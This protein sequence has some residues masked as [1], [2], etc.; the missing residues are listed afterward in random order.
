MRE[1]PVPYGWTLQCVT[2]KLALTIDRS[3]S[4]VV[5]YKWHRRKNVS[6]QFYKRADLVGY[7]PGNVRLL[8]RPESDR[9]RRGPSHPRNAVCSPGVPSTSRLRLGCAPA[10]RRRT[11]AY[12]WKTTWKGTLD[13]TGEG[14]IKGRINLGN[15]FQC[16]LESHF[17]R[18]LGSR[19]P[20]VM[21]SGGGSGRCNCILTPFRCR[22]HVRME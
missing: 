12:R 2:W 15:L 20:K 10:D 1:I 11:I 5:C 8:P 17:E 6:Q 22:I 7:V 14:N 19:V 21:Q 13:T 4:L 16:C 3:F 9:H 18:Y